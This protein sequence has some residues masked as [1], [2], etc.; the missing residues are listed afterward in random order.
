[1]GEFLRKVD[2]SRDFSPEFRR[3]TVQGILSEGRPQ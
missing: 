3:E 2:G 1:M